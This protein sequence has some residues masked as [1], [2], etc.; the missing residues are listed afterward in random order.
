MHQPIQQ[1]PIAVVG[2]ACR[3][4]GG[5]TSPSKLW[6]LLREPRDVLKE[7]DP[8]RLNLKRFYH[9]DGDV[10]G[11]T[12][13]Q[14]KAYLLEDDT[15]VFDAFFFGISPFEAS[16][17]DPQQRLLLEVVYEAFESAGAVLDQL[18]GAL[19]S[20][21]V[22]AMTA[23]YASIQLRD[24]EN[25]PK[26]TATAIADSFLS[27]GISYIFDLMGPSETI[28]TACSSSLV[29]LHN[30]VSGLIAGDCETAVV[31]GVNLIL[32]SACFINESKLHMR[33]QTAGLVC[34]ARTQTGM[35]VERALQPSYSSRS[36][37]L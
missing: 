2:M 13:V 37:R 24:L 27:N 34:G 4:P 33:H 5:A 28:D 1:E 19:T 14:N 6:Q 31:A 10:H 16:G 11:C 8:D 32:D 9:P 29:A 35:L 30:A 15:R 36:V 12:N 22:G 20:V 25:A 18:K 23:D 26:Y 3:F 21:H 17:M 7:F